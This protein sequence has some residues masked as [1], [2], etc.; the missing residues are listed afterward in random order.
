MGRPG[1]FTGGAGG[2]RGRRWGGSG[3]PGRWA[4]P[5]AWA[6]AERVGRLGGLTGGAGGEPGAW[7]GRR[8]RAAVGAAA[9]RAGGR[10]G[11]ERRK[12]EKTTCQAV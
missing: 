9:C 7:G 12:R 3:V 5:G 1:G 8:S 10:E 11:S 4:W 6:A 2:C